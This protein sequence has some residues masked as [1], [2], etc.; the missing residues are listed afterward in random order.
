[1]SR[2]NILILWYTSNR[3]QRV[4]KD[5]GVSNKKLLMAGSNKRYRKVYG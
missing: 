5:N 3:I 1:M 2:D 4:I